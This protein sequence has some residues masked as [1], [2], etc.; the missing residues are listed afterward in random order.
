MLA[1]RATRVVAPISLDSALAT[2]HFYILDDI[3]RA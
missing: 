3:Q 2:L 1:R